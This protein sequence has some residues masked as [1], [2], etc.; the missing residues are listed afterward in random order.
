MSRGSNPTKAQQW[1]GRLERFVN[2]GKSVAQF[3]QTEGVS[4]PSFYQW[5][6]KLGLGNRK[7]N[8]AAR[9]AKSP[10]L[11]GKPG[12]T[13]TPIQL[14]P[15]CGP[16]RSTTIRLAADVEIELGNDLH[17]IDVVVRSVVKQ[18]LSAGVGD[19]RC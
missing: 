18:V 16:V 5:R 14:T 7:G 12:A 19:A 8:R 4:Q 17:V 6:K 3:C 1:S 9:L 2:S 15:T 10:N 13:F 11:R